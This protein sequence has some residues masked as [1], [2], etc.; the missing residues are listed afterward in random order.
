MSPPTTGRIG[1]VPTVT[2]TRTEP[3][4][5]S[6][7]VATLD[8]VSRGRSG[9]VVG[10]SATEAARGTTDAVA[11]LRGETGERTGNG[12]FEGGHAL[13]GSRPAGPS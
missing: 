4:P 13:G 6:T 5:V 12:R 8:R 1:L 2:T 3:F 10:I 9:R 7:T 11:A